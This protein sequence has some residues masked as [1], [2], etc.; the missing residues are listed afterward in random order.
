M[1]PSW[2]LNVG[3]LLGFAVNT[4]F[5]FLSQSA[6]PH[7]NAELSRKYQSLA[8]PAGFTFAI[9][10]LIFSA[11]G[12]FTVAQLIVPTLRGADEVRK[13]APW[14]I[15]ACIFQAAWSVAFGFERIALS[16]VL[17]LLIFA[18]LWRMNV[19]LQRLADGTQLSWGLY[20]LCHLPFSIHF[21]WLTAASAVSVN[22]SLVAA[23]PH[24][25]TTLFS[26]AIMS[27][28]FV[29]VLALGVPSITP[30]G[31]DTGYALTIAWALNGIAAQ[32]RSPLVK[33]PEADPIKAWCPPFVTD[34]LALVASALA[35][36]VVASIFL[37]VINHA[38]RSRSSID[39]SA[40]L[41]DKLITGP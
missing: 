6:L 14:F 31:P 35:V 33:A 23:R 21:A 8:T 19:L 37:R 25:H 15:A 20:L 26:L 36:M 29:F 40:S 22:I 13:P 28:A 27:L 16:Q 18:S 24:D 4:A 41:V 7:N 9:W 17:I 30:K 32:L 11:E 38:V 39:P 10:G 3:I 34:G 5:T 12:A 2:L 1:A